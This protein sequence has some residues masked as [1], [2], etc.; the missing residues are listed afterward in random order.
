MSQSQQQTPLAVITIHDACPAFSTKIFKFT[1]EL[2]NLGVRYN[3]AL[4]PFFK[5]KQDLPRFLGFV[6]KIKSCKGEI[7]LH[8]LYHENRRGFCDDF[9]TRSKAA[10]EEEIRAGIEILQEIGI[11]S[12][13]FIPP[14]WKLNLNSIEVLGK[15]GFRLA[16]IM[17]KYVLLHS[18]TFKKIPV[19]KVLNWDSYGDPEKN[20]VNIT[21][22]RIRFKFLTKEDKRRLIRIALHPR[23]PY[24][25][26]EDQKEMILQLKE[27]GYQMLRYRDLIPRL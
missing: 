20:I 26:L 25:A 8:G 7:V 16:E 15:L 18:R 21:R 14:C 11:R 22:N 24:H 10:A 17:E 23:D 2:E 27:Q 3:T 13:V 12:N 1:N 5:E 9:H 19:S 6:D 4:V